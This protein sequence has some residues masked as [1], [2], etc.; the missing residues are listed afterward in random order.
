MRSRRP[1]LPLLL[2]PATAVGRASQ[3]RPGTSTAASDTHSE[4]ESRR[5]PVGIVNEGRWRS[6]LP[7]L[8][9]AARRKKGADGGRLSDVVS[10]GRSSKFAIQTAGTQSTP[11]SAFPFRAALIWGGERPVTRSADPESQAVPANLEFLNT[12]AWAQRSLASLGI[13]K[14]RIDATGLARDKKPVPEG[15]GEEE[16]KNAGERFPSLD[17]GGHSGGKSAKEVKNDRE[18]VD[19]LSNCLPSRGKNDDRC[20]GIGEGEL[21]W[22]TNKQQVSV[23]R[24]L[25]NS[26]PALAAS[27]CGLDIEFGLDVDGDGFSSVDHGGLA[28]FEKRIGATELILAREENSD[29]SQPSPVFLDHRSSKCVFTAKRPRFDILR[30]SRA[31]KLE[32]PSESRVPDTAAW[33]AGHRAEMSGV[34]RRQKVAKPELRGRKQKA[35]KKPAIVPG[36]NVRRDRQTVTAKGPSVNLIRYGRDANPPSESR[37]AQHG[38]VGCRLL[39]IELLREFARDMAV[40][41]DCH[42]QLTASQRRVAACSSTTC[43]CQAAYSAE[44]Q[45]QPAVARDGEARRRG[46]GHGSATVALVVSLS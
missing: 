32:L 31:R 21:S 37:G 26:G 40:R 39:A 30:I 35:R 27:E 36:R 17:C 20:Y 16:R 6:P 12:A 46:N 44:S 22:K 18:P 41:A 43:N 24:I 4:V 11:A 38:R 1:P 33:T 29:S 8:P 23:S 42:S 14:S 25:K 10:E 19:V 2:L 34:Q 15:E 9:S 45:N 7:V 3:T 13:E 5:R 28:S